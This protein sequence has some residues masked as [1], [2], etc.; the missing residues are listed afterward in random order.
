MRITLQL[1]GGFAGESVPPV[2]VDADAVRIRNMSCAK[3][4]AMS[5]IQ[6]DRAFI[7]HQCLEFARGKWF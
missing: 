5:H 7:I 1:K 3:L 2:S 6:H 4:C